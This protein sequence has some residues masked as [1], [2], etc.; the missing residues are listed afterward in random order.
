MVFLAEAERNGLEGG[1]AGREVTTPSMEAWV[2]WS[3]GGTTGATEVERLRDDA[4]AEASDDGVR[5]Y[6]TE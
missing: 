3:N 4:A 2:G 1:G 5:L 6:L